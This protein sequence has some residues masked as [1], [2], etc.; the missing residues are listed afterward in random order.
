MT[1]VSAEGR[2]RD[3][4]QAEGDSTSDSRR[5]GWDFEAGTE[6][7]PGRTVVRRLGG[8]ERY[9]A[10]LGWDDHLATT[11]VLKTLR[12]GQVASTRARNSIAREAGTLRALA[13]PSIVRCFAAETE[14]PQPHLVLE[15]L[16]GP[17]LST[18]IRRY[19]PLTSEQL[20]PLALELCSALAYM[21]NEG[22]VHLDVKPQNVIMGAQ[23]RLIDLSIA[24]RIAEV[25]ALGG[26]LGT[27]AYMAP[28]Q[29]VVERLHEIGPWTDVWG[30]GATLY[31]AANGHRPF[32][33]NANGEPLAQLT[34]D[35]QK[36]H[37]RVPASIAAVIR[38]CLS[39][40]TAARPRLVDVRDAFED[41]MLGARDEALRR[42]RRRVR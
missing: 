33:R 38:A 28:E 15:F 34:E 24:R 21:H 20:V 16:D 3:N 11:V 18:L 27:A 5:A 29:A 32:S 39:R 23:P 40:D 31:E 19:G 10:W 9:E 25:S 22:W 14:G 2:A 41:L 12:P 37:A 8:G 1:E 35:P 4:A 7:A 17:R 6:V 13:H 26:T 42:L 30:L 36:F